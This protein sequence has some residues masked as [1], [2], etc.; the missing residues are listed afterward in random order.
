MA[1]MT[2][3]QKIEKVKNSIQK[4]E[5]II[6]LSSAKVKELNKELKSLL[7][8]KDQQ[9]A[10]DFLSLMSENGFT[11]DEDKTQFMQMIKEQF[12]VSI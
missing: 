9:Y 10:N 11:S 1:K 12:G 7:A 4:E 3:D 2:L 6:S 5:E 8:E